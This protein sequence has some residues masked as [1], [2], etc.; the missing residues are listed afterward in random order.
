L[1]KSADPEYTDI[2]IEALHDKSD[3]VINA[4]AVALGKTKSPKAFE[5]LMNLENQKSWK[6]QNRISALNGLQ[7]LGDPRALEYVL[8]C[9]KDNQSPRWYLATPIWDYPFA[10]VHTLVALGKADLAYPVLLERFKNSL[11]D[12]DINDVFQ[13]VQLIDLLKDNRAVEVYQLLK[14]KFGQDTALM[15][16]IKTYEQQYSESL[17]P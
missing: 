1:G 13:N 7:Q 3:R 9:I 12:N 15:E 6:N 2:Y 5:I 4:A 8:N 14:E 16:A 17:K 11:K 10:A